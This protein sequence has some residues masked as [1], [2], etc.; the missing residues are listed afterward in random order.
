MFAFLK[1][2]PTKKLKKR[3]SILLEQAMQAQRK[4]DIR[5]YSELTAEAEKVADEI[6]RLGA[7]KA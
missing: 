3:H 7:N 5:T 4:G 6:Q 2:D 1:S